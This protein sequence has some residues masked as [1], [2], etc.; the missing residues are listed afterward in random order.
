MPPVPRLLQRGEEWLR[1][2][3][4]SVQPYLER[5]PSNVRI[6]LPPVHPR[7]R[8]V[9]FAHVFW[10]GRELARGC[11][12]TA[13]AGQHVLRSWPTGQYTKL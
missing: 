8:C 2:Q 12:L 9:G 11:C 10:T 5:L 6:R 13:V 1:T 3:I 4:A 7:R